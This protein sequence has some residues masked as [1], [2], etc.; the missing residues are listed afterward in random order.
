MRSFRA[1]CRAF[2]L[3][4]VAVVALVSA[5]CSD[6]DRVAHPA[7]A[8]S[9]NAS[10]G[11]LRLL[12]VRIETPADTVHVEGDNVGLFLTIANAGPSAD[13]LTAVATVD[14]QDVVFRDGTGPLRADIGVDVPPGGVASMQYPG[15]PHLELVGLRRDVGGGRFMPVTFRFRKAGA[16]TVDVFVQAYA[17]PSVA[18]LPT[19]PSPT[20][21]PSS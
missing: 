2:L 14:A 20:T 19:I 10:L 11:A 3:A 12:A 6:G 8:D 13:T 9:I 1:R 16:T 17:H 4:A 5:A 21:P 7:Q 15:G 18:P